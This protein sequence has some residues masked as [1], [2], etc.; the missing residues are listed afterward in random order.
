WTMFHSYAF[1]FSVWELWGALIYG[2]KLVVVPYFVSRSP[3]EFYRLLER[4]KVTVLNQTPSS[5]RQLMHAEETLQT[6]TPLALR[7]VIFGAEELEMQSLRPWFERH[8][9]RG[10]QLVN[11]YGITETTVHVTYRPLSLADTTS[12]SVI[13]YPIPDLQVYLLDPDLQPTPIGVPGEMYVGGAGVARGYLNRPELNNERFIPD[14]FRPGTGSRLYK[15]GDLARRLAN[16]DMEYLGRIDQQVKIRGFR[17]ELG[18]I[19][20]ALAQHAGVKYAVVIDREDTPGD[21]RLVAYLVANGDSPTSEELRTHL[22]QSLPEYMVPSAFVALASLP[23]TA[24]GKVDRRALPVPDGMLARS[25]ELVAPRT[26]TEEMLAGIWA[27]V[28]RLPTIGVFDDFFVLGGH[29]LLATQVVARVQKQAQ[30]HVTLRM[31]FEHSTIASL[32]RAID[33]C[34]STSSRDEP[35]IVPISMNAFLVK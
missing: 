11:M 25:E 23:L 14:A 34:E 12:G 2:G 26:A 27:E 28:L 8:G 21:K 3:E 29:S 7:Y 30:R 22:K 20:S 1:D 17:I 15:S 31:L 5:F 35:V 33:E 18:E 13:G 4:E 16:G 32:A 9:D 6:S 24:N 19:E 10:P